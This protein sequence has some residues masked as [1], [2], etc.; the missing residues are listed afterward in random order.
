MMSLLYH[1][2]CFWDLVLYSV[3]FLLKIWFDN[4]AKNE[5]FLEMV[6]SFQTETTLLRQ[7]VGNL[8]KDMTN[9]TNKTWSPDILLEMVHTETNW[10]KGRFSTLE[11]K[12]T[13]DL[14]HKTQSMTVD[15]E[16]LFERIYTVESFNCTLTQW[17]N[18]LIERMCML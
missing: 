16:T 1:Y 11:K 3:Y 8:K 4:R 15:A 9:L 13:A 7:E 6:Q 12:K 18:R 2:F 17:H 14:A 5:A 10:F